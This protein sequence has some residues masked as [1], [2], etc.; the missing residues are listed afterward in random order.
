MPSHL[1]LTIEQ[2]RFHAV[3]VEEQRQHQPDRAAADDGDRSIFDLVRHPS[4]E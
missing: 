2:H 3:M 1:R 4:L